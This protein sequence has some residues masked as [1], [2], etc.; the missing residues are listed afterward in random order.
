MIIDFNG[1]PNIGVFASCNEEIVIISPYIP[2]SARRKISDALKV[3]L[4][5][6]LIGGSTAVGCLAVGNSHGFLLSSFAS[7]EEVEKIEEMGFNVKRISGKYNAVG[8][9]IVAND[10]VAIASP[11]LSKRCL[12]EIERVLEVEVFRGTI[13]GLRN[14]GM[15]AVATNKGVLVHPNVTRD[16]AEFL[17]EKFGLPVSVGTV[18]SG[19]PFVRSALLANSKGYVV[20]SDTTGPEIG[21]IEDA[22]DLI[23][24][25]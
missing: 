3:E 12:E 22:L 24:S 19:F 20:G 5:E 9:L 18:N 13:A 10:E 23:G 1:N 14:I 21:R 11:S 6:T 4:V 16:E 25:F 15:A 8:N 17:E 7:D 2:R